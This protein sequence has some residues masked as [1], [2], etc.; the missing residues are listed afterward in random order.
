MVE[1]LKPFEEAMIEDLSFK[2]RLPIV[3]GS[4][5]DWECPQ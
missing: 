1:K 5:N 2:M 4:F 3:V